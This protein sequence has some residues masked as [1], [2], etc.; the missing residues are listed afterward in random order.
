MRLSSSL[1]VPPEA[2]G[3][4]A[5]AGPFQAA[6]KADL[7]RVRL[8]QV[9]ELPLDRLAPLSSRSLTAH[10]SFKSSIAA[11]YSLGRLV[12]IARTCCQTW[13]C[14]SARAARCCSQRLPGHGRGGPV[15]VPAAEPGAD[16]AGRGCVPQIP[17]ARP[18]SARPALFLAGLLPEPAQLR[19]GKQAH[20]RLG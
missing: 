11:S 7:L 12:L 16:L 15:L 8:A 10:K 19:P 3:S 2:P 4:C 6:Q 20:L 17:T 1:L 13:S 18:R 14:C 5:E 9:L